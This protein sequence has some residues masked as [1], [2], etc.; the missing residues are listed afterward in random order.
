[1]KYFK[2]SVVCEQGDMCRMSVSFSSKM[3]IFFILTGV[4]V[5]NYVPLVVNSDLSPEG[6]GNSG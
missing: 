5:I 1:M 2:K 3:V 6:E 4:E